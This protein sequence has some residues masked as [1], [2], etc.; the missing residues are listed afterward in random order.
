MKYLRSS[1]LTVVFLSFLIGC[2][3]LYTGVVTVT[4]TVDVAMKAW[5]ELSVA[6]KTTIDVDAKVRLAHAK[7]QAACAIAR[8]ALVAYKAGGDAQ[9]YAAAVAAAKS[10]A[11][12]VIDLIMPLLLP[13]KAASIKTQ[14]TKANS[15]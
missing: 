2:S 4:E 15:L 5:A 6:G 11:A 9:Q 8:D 10:A 3:S 1:I 12:G 13:D 7:Y 14:F